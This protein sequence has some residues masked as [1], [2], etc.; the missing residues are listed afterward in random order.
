M[1]CCILMGSPRRNGNT[2]AL[3]KPFIEELAT[4]GVEHEL[5]WLYD[6][7][8]EPCVACRTCQIDWS[9]FGCK[10][11]DDV[12]NIFDKVLAICLFLQLQSIHGIV[13]RQ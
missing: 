2:A 11:N 10:Y 6:K 7:N 4:Y 8:I 5:I 13:R 1:K 12:Q 9:I 3:L